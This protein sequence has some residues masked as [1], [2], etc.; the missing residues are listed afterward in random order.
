MTSFYHEDNDKIKGILIVTDRIIR[1][2]KLFI[3]KKKY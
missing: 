3:G 1:Y 2:M